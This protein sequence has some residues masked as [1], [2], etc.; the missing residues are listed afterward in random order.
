MQVGILTYRRPALLATL[1]PQVLEQVEALHAWTRGPTG[2]LVVDNDPAGS[3][4]GVCAAHPDVR[5]VLEPAPGIAAGRH[6][7]LDESAGWDLLQFIDDD[8]EPAP[9]WLLTMVQTWSEHDRPAVVAGS[10][11]TRYLTPPSPWIVAGQFFER[12]QPETGT[13]LNVAAS[14]NMLIDVS[15]VR[16]LGVQFDR[17]L[18]LHGGSDTLFSQDVH[19]GGGRLIA[20]REGAIYDLV[21]A[22]H[23]N[24]RWALQ[25]AWHLGQSRSFMA[26]YG[27]KDRR[28]RWRVRVR[29][30]LGGLARFGQGTVQAGLGLLLRSDRLH[31]RGLRWVHRSR[32]VMAGAVGGA[33][34]KYPR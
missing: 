23:S 25:R 14:G 9:D 12:R 8:E 17:E 3:A 24:R 29:L 19:R 22:D 16:R 34:P 10:V 26:L 5:Y 4:R 20:C 7:A 32:G 33:T 27:E 6:R 11:R 15:E 28:R 2:V 31:A 18:G 21:P 1:L 30:M 13:P